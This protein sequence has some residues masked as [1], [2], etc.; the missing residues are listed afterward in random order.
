VIGTEKSLLLC[1]DD[2]RSVS[3]QGRSLK[4][5]YQKTNGPENGWS[6]YLLSHALSLRIVCEPTA[7]AGLSMR[8]SQTRK[9]KGCRRY[10]QT[11]PPACGC[12]LR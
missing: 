5:P 6:F 9:V 11:L 8:Q 2:G 3:A 7:T 4:P 12:A 1:S 10:L